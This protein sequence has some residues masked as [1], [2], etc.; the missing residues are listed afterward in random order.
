MKDFIDFL[1]NRTFHKHFISAFVGLIVFIFLIFLSLRVYTRHGQ[2][3]SVPDFSGLSLEEAS[4]IT[5]LKKLRFVIIDSIFIQGQEPG[6]VVAQNPSPNTKVKENRTIFFT[7]NAFNPEK[8]KMPNILGLSYRLAE[9]TLINNGL[10][11]GARRYVP[12]I[13]RDYV[14]R[15]I[16]KN[17]EIKPGTL[18]LKG[19]AVDLVLG[20]GEGSSEITVPDVKRLTLNN[21]IEALSEMYINLGAIIYDNSVETREDSLKAI[22]YKQ[23][24]TYGATIRSG[25]EIDVWLTTDKSKAGISEPDSISE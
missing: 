16:F 8:V 22:I 18:I 13:G 5:D 19:S 14:L 2:A 23:N 10:K 4:K 7:I 3:L 25:N 20:L 24:P 12:D 11:V 15:Q 9:T 21:A 17:R 6:T 1:K